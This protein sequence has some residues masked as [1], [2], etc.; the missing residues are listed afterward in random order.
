MPEPPPVMSTTW[1]SDDMISKFPGS[2]ARYDLKEFPGI[3]IC[4]VVFRLC[5]MFQ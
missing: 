1:G 5:T 3:L 4:C 2:P